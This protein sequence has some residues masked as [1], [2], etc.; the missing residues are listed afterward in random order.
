MARSPETTSKIMK[1]I[2]S[3][4]TKPEKSVR[5]ILYSA[6]YRGYRV[7]YKKISGSPDICFTKWKIAIFVNGC[8]WH[9]CPYC[10][11]SN[12]SVNKEFW[13]RKFRKNVERDKRYR[14]QLRE[15]NWEVVTIWE[16]KL[17]K[18]PEYQVNRVIIKLKK[19]QL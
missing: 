7:N 12:P 5:H 10:N 1:S 14:K 2:R 8:F 6:G 15:E 19:L 4:D 11:P 13:D 9:R 18:N 17:K 3:Q 16:C